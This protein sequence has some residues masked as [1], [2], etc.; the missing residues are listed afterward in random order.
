MM[1]VYL[2][3]FS[4]HRSIFCLKSV[5]VSH[6]NLFM[7]YSVFKV[8]VLLTSCPQLSPRYLMF[9]YLQAGLVLSVIRLPLQ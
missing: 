1:L 5:F 2:I 8:Q 3:L 9:P 7:K 4:A 6:N